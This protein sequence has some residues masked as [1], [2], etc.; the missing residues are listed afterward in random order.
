MSSR[1]S[2]CPL[3]VLSHFVYAYMMAITVVLIVIVGARRA[4]IV[5]RLVRLGIVG[6]VTLAVTAFQWFPLITLRDYVSVSPYLQ[7]YKYDSFGAPAILGWLFSGDL[8]DHGRLPVLTLLFVLGIGVALV[9]RT[10]LNIFVLTGFLVW[11]VLYFGRPTLGPLFDLFPL[12]DGLLIHRFIG[13]M[14]L[15]VVPL[16]GLGGALDLGIWSTA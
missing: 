12:S 5:P 3:L 15:F 11:L 16:I 4:T 8:F 10:R 9:R 1:C 7:Q 2:R 14:E 13:E 6:V